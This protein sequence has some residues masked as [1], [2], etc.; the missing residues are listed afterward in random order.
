MLIPI[1][2]TPGVMVLASAAERRLGA[3]AAGW[4]AALP[5]SL[6]VV[7]AALTLE[8]GP[9][10]GDVAFSAAAH[11]SAQVLLAVVA[12]RLLQ[13]RGFALAAT[14]GFVTYAGYSVISPNVPPILAVATAIPMLAAAPRL[15][16]TSTPRPGSRRGPALTALM[17]GAGLVLVV[18]ALLAARTAG[19][20]L[21]GAVGA[22]PSVSLTLTAAV[23]WSSGRAAGTQ[24]L[25]GLVRGLPGYLA[26]CVTAALL[27]EP[28]GLLALPISMAA[29]ALTGGVTW[30]RVTIAKRSSTPTGRTRRPGQAQLASDDS[31]MTLKAFPRRF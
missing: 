4:I 22:F 23:T 3:S 13:R 30:R 21:A 24:V 16:P 18:G 15:L 11:V 29:C 28:A 8:S 25:V 7:I 19:P 9:K 20:D 2:V 5:M 10:A 12:G 1:L 6:T 26:F 17:C 27:A 14:A 31:T